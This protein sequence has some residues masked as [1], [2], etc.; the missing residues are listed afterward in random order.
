MNIATFCLLSVRYKR[1]PVKSRDQSYFRRKK[2][3]FLSSLWKFTQ[4]S[5]ALR[6]DQNREICFDLSFCQL[7]CMFIFYTKFR[8]I[9]YENQIWLPRVK[10]NDF[11][12][13]RFL[14]ATTPILWIEVL[15]SIRRLLKVF[16]WRISGVD[17]RKRKWACINAHELLL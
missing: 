7:I 14:A 17:L 15:N 5:W 8:P 9:Y 4:L 13:N 16:F 2:L 12:P 11:Q 6:S 3:S 10:I 1:F